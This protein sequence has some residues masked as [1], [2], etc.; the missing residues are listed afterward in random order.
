ML[1]HTQR[2][3]RGLAARELRQLA[4]ETESLRRQVNEWRAAYPNA[5]VTGAHEGPIKEPTRSVEFM[6]LMELED[7]PE[8][9]AMSEAERIAYEMRG[10]ENGGLGGF[11]DEEDMD[12]GDE[13]L[14]AD[15]TAHVVPNQ[16]VPT[17]GVPAGASMAPVSVQEVI[18]PSPTGV[19]MPYQR[20]SMLALPTLRLSAAAATCPL[21]SPPECLPST[22]TATRHPATAATRPT[23]TSNVY[24]H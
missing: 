7:V 2:R 24:R 4:A 19:N 12:F 8:E 11:G 9:M 21:L 3:Q 6:L 18:L 16:T 20:T 10:G 23:P 17:S 22:T 1:I 13:E 14:Y 5:S 15:L